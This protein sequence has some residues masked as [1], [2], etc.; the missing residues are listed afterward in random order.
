MDPISSESREYLRVHV[1]GAAGV[2][3]VEIAFTTPGVEPL[4]GQWHLA[5]WESSGHESAHARILVGPDADVTLAAG[6]YQ[7]WTRITRD[8][9][10]PVLPCGLVPVI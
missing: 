3:P 1:E 4:E 8:P 2:E 10:R 7:A 5:E 6:T 9:E